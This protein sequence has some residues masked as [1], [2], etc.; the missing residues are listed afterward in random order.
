MIQIQKFQ[1]ISASLNSAQN[2]ETQAL[3]WHCN[4]LKQLKY[5]HSIGNHRKSGDSQVFWFI[6]VAFCKG[7]SIS[8][9]IS[10]S[11]SQSIQWDA[12]LSGWTSSKALP[13]TQNVCT[14]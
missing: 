6:K 5:V 10:K 1:P 3:I 2:F 12:I 13:K 9:L 14:F 4:T 7:T 8:V 11:N